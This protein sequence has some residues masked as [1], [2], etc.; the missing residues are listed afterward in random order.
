[1]A[2]TPA[3]LSFD[4]G[5]DPQTGQLVEVAP[6]LWRVTAG[7]RSPYTFTGNNSFLVGCETVALLDPGPDEAAHHAALAKAIGGRKVA[8]IVLTHTHRDHSA[9]AA[10][11]KAETGA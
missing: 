8:A 2:D 4:T 3:P 9:S 11:W 6:G 1:M 7:N 5:F 10:R